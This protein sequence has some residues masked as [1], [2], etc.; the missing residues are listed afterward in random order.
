[1]YPQT[2]NV[3]L[4]DWKFKYLFYP[5]NYKKWEDNEEKYEN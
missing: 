2:I 4:Q 1:M 5:Q 3:P